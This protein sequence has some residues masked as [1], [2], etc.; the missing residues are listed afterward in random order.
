MIDGQSDDKA[1]SLFDLI[2]KLLWDVYWTM[3]IGRDACLSLVIESDECWI[4]IKGGEIILITKCASL[5]VYKLIEEMMVQVNVCAAESL[6]VK[7]LLLIYWVYD[8]PSLEKV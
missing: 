1:G 2:F 8:M 4:I 3:K 7:C 5:E 6:E